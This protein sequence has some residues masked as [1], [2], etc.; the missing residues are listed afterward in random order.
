[1]ASKAEQERLG[2]APVVIGVTPCATCKWRDAVDPLA[3]KAF[4]RIPQ[5]VL[6][7]QLDHRT[8]IAGDNGF[9]YEPVR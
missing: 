2:D 4:E 9:L 6:R 3:C 7:G 1:L 5:A 8:P